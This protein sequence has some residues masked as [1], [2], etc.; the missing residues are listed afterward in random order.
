MKV[1]ESSTSWKTPPI[2]AFDHFHLAF[3]DL[4]GLGDL[5]H[6]KRHQLTELLQLVAVLL[7]DRGHVHV[8]PSVRVEQL[9]CDFFVQLGIQPGM[10][11]RVRPTATSFWSVAMA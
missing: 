8:D 4:A 5:A 6:E 1:R 7:V 3:V 10:F 2:K 11:L 9:L